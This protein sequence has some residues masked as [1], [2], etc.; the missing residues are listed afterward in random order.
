MICPKCHAEYREGFYRCV[1]CDVPLISE[2]DTEMDF[3]DAEDSS[4]PELQP[5]F[6]TQDSS[7]LSD[8][9]ALVEENKIPYILQSGTAIGRDSLEQSDALE[10]RAVLYVPNQL[11]EMVESFIA[12]LKSDRS[13]EP[14]VNPDAE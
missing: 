2:T 10:W 11:E 4:L 1:E 6:E 12:K 5:V 3:A 8:L 13:K 9:V 7:F 14:E